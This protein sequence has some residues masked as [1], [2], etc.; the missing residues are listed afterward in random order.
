MYMIL[1]VPSKSSKATKKAIRDVAY[2]HGIGRHTEDE[3]NQIMR[4]DLTSL[5]N[6]L[7]KEKVKWIIKWFLLIMC[8]VSIYF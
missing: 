8:S 5:S 2:K 7:G 4:D 1:G 3:V 6:F